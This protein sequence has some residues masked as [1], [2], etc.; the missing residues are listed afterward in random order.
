M[1]PEEQE[2]AM[3]GRL[4][5]LVKKEITL[6]IAKSCNKW[7][8]GVQ[9]KRREKAALENPYLKAVSEDEKLEKVRK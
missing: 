6:Q 1:E 2:R 3:G 8:N 9:S 5:E 7:Q 4:S